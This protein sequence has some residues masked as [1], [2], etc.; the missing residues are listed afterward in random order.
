MLK[1]PAIFSDGAVFQRRKN[2][3]VWGWTDPNT[4]LEC[5]FASHKLYTVSSLLSGKFSFILPP[6][7][8]DHKAHIL[9]IR[10]LTGN[11]ELEVKDILIGEV[12]LASG[13]SNMEFRL[14]ASESQMEEF[15]AEERSA[16]EINTLRMFTVKKDSLGV[17]QDDCRG[18]WEVSDNSHV[19]HW[20]AVALWF[21]KKLQKELSVPIGLINSSWG[22]TVVETWTS[23]ERFFMDQK[24]KDIIL[25]A[26]PNAYRK[27]A[28]EDI[29]LPLE[30]HFFN[31]ADQRDY[32][33]RTC[34]KDD[35]ITEK[36]A[37]WMNVDFDDSSWKDLQVPG[38]W[39]RQGAGKH[40]AFWYRKEVT[41][42]EN[43]AG[44]EIYLCMST[45]DKQDSCYF[46][47]VKVGSSGKDFEYTGANRKYPVPEEIVKAGKAVIAM[48]AY[49]FIY[50]AGIYGSG[51]ECFLELAGTEE[52]I[53]LAGLWKGCQ[54]TIVPVPPDV[55]GA[56]SDSVICNQ[57]FRS[58]LYNGMIH[59]LIPYTLAGFIWYQGE[60]NTGN[61]PAPGEVLVPAILYRKNMADLIEDW[62]FR[63]GEKDL[64]FIMVGIAGYTDAPEYMEDSSWAKLRESQRKCASD[65]ENV[66][67]ASAVDCGE[68]KDVHP[69][70]KKTVGSRLAAQALFHTY[71]RNDVIPEGP[72]P[73]KTSQEGNVLRIDFDFAEGMKS[74]DG[75]EI[76]GFYIAGADGRFFP[77]KTDIYGKSVLLSCEEV[78]RPCRVRYG[79]SNYPVC[80]LVN[81]AE[82]PAFPFEM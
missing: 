14:S 73:V 21:G 24:Q 43:W 79:W 67:V 19:P 75:K 1:L 64:P 2:I 68:R 28:W 25:S 5:E 37:A 47:G 71:Y 61:T 39:I 59:P 17:L 30:T 36:A 52:R 80:T 18:K 32:F 38:D 15:L 3:S 60:A 69:K 62:R 76:R 55:S 74:S 34:R 20:S 78:P 26:L 4:F 40:G 49:S 57:N 9:K 42:P 58:N 13:Q 48:R 29:G 77:A 7:E 72:R 65:L 12:W 56:G 16:E 46:N 27:K 50:G 10:N 51:E 82:L 66:F 70:D 11:E 22:G 45:I 31:T 41:I 63:W 33:H 81:N 6:M 53:M 54:E 44:R 35:G 8:A 23:Q